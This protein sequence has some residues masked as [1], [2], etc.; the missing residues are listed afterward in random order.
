MFSNCG[1]SEFHSEEQIKLK[2]KGGSN[3][4]L[5]SFGFLRCL[6]LSVAS[7]TRIGE[8]VNATLLLAALV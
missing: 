2:F 1:G 8:V 4:I 7:E 3:R 5:H 6:G